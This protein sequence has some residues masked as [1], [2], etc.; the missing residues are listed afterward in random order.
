MPEITCFIKECVEGETTC[1][2][3]SIF[4]CRYQIKNQSNEIDANQIKPMQIISKSL[5][6]SQK[7]F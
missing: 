5:H 1:Y 2:L 6:M 4:Q 7:N 3:I